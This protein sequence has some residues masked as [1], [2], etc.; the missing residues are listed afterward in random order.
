M[1]D[2]SNP[3]AYRSGS[4]ADADLK[5]REDCLYNLQDPNLK[6]VHEKPEH[7][8]MILMKAGGASNGAIAE[9]MDYTQ[10]HVSQIL[11]QPWAVSRILDEIRKRGDDGAQGLLR[12]QVVDSILTLVEIRDD[13]SATHAVRSDACKYFINRQF[14]LPNQ[15]IIHT[16]KD[17]SK[18]SDDDLMRIAVGESATTVQ[19]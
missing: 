7:R 16:Q 8:M 18:L 11:R 3:Q 12:E 19:N 13:P 10:A 4:T 17:F 6:V 1:V 9:A 15:P 5:E 2:I 14:G